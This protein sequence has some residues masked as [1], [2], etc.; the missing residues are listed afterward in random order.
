MYPL[1]THFLFSTNF[2]YGGE[3]VPTIYGGERVPNFIYGGEHVPTLSW[4][5]GEH[6]PK[7]IYGGE[8][9]PTLYEQP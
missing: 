8:H 2:Q 9:V 6:V 4:Y 1:Y 3:P 5:G 7:F